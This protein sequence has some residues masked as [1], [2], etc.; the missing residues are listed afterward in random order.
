MER[1][2]LSRNAPLLASI[3][4]AVLG[5][6]LLAVYMRQFQRTAAG[7]RPVVLL[8]MRK[9]VPAGEPIREEM[10]IAHAVPESYVESRQILASE[11]PRVL[12]VRAAI[13]L[14]VNQTLAWTDLASTRR[15]RGSL[16]TRIPPGMRAMSISETGRKAFGG[17]LRPGDR[18]DV[19]LSKVKPEPDARTVTI[20]LLQNILVL[21]VGNDLGA[22]YPASESQRSDF[23]TLLLS[24]DQASLLAHGKRGGELSLILRNES[25]LEINESLPETTDL[26]VLTQ[27]R[28]ARKQ[29]RVLIERVD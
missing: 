4:V 15:D 22:I 13:D 6:V 11:K 20:P 2:R 5:G 9:D 18:V 29:R 21:A 1:A 12:G 17:L 27:E 14:E 3:A 25:D 10:L 7:G 28:R 16:S 24:V 23:V 8:A 19:L 26:D